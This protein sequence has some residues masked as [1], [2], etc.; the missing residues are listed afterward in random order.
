VKELFDSSGAAPR[1]ERDQIRDAPLPEQPEDGDTGKA[2]V[3]R[4]A[5]QAH[6]LRPDEPEQPCEDCLHLFAFPDKAQRQHQPLA[7]MDDL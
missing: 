7:L 4:E 1:R 2:L 5:A 3:G 6:A